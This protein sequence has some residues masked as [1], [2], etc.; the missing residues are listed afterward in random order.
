MKTSPPLSESELLNRCYQLAGKTLNDVACEMREP[1]PSSLHHAKGW[2]GQL[3]EKALGANAV[4]LDQPDFIDLGIELKTIPVTPSGSPCESTYICMASI[5]NTDPSWKGSRVFRKMAKMLW[6]P[7]ES[8]DDKPLAQAKIGT[9][10]L[11]SP[12]I[13]IEAQLQQDWEEL[14]ELI[15]LGHYEELSASKGKFLQIRPKAANAKT[16]IQVIDHHG[17]SISVVPKGFYLRTLLTKQILQENYV[18]SKV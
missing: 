5:P 4:N 10:I 16:F 18:L 1:T 11:W 2:I 9:P 14:I 13:D 3:I 8:N 12:P 6:V 17:Q 15:T 7:I